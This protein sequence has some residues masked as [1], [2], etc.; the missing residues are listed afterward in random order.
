MNG[1]QQLVALQGLDDDIRKLE[2][3]KKQLKQKAADAASASQHAHDD[4]DA[5]TAAVTN[6]RKEMDKREGDLKVFEDQINKLSTQLNTIK[7]N[8]EYSAIQGEILN[9]KQ[10]M[11]KVEDDILRLME[12]VDARQS[13]S[14]DLKAK[15]EAADADVVKKKQAIT[16]AIEDADARI[17]RITGERKAMADE[18][19]PKFLEPYDRL[20]K[21]KA[22]LSA[23]AAC[24]NFVCQGCRMSLTANTVNL[25][26]SGKDIIYCHS[27]QRIL[28]IPTDEDHQ[29]G[30]GAGRS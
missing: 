22:G 18:I 16:D 10:E 6:A 26:M 8:K 24:R 5:G 28:Y 9:A 15:V 3:T 29:D 17:E 11:S 1:M 12:E 7:T 2:A 4:L 20:R 25:L 14:G 23:L 21:G 27:C 13:E 30:Q 19:G